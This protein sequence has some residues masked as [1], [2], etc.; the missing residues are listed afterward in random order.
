MAWWNRL[1]EPPEFTSDQLAEYL[2]RNPAANPN[3]VAKDGGQAPL[4]TDPDIYK[5]MYTAM[6]KVAAPLSMSPSG[7]DKPYNEAEALTPN[8]AGK[9]PSTQ[10]F[11]DTA[12]AP[13]T[14]AA[15]MFGGL[16]GKAALGAGKLAAGLGGK[17]AMF[18]AAGAADRAAIEAAQKMWARGAPD[19]DVLRAT[20]LSKG[21]EGVVQKEIPGNEARLHPDLIDK[22]MN[23]PTLSYRNRL[24][25][26]LEHPQLWKERPELAAI[27]TQLKLAPDIDAAYQGMRATDPVGATTWADRFKNWNVL[28]P[29]HIKA[30]GQ[31]DTW[32]A[33][34]L[35]E[36]QHPVQNMDR[37]A[38]GG[39][40][41]YNLQPGTNAWTLYQK[42]LQK[43]GVLEPFEQFL[44]TQPSIEQAIP[45]YNKRTAEM[46]KIFTNLNKRD[47]IAYDAYHQLGG[48]VQ[49]RNT[50][51]PRRLMSADETRNV[52]PRE[53]EDV[54]R[55]DQFVRISHPDYWR[56]LY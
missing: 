56:P 30:E 16:A 36:T 35:H 6:P 46:G 2:R 15:E 23:S 47:D 14:G 10:E 12:L 13:F 52:L 19:L 4:Q 49:A 29:G 50:E 32:L 5:Q 44:Q 3:V 21:V 40:V 55:E 24:D 31:P 1:N 48:E 38:S 27:P 33:T 8:A 22:V 43:I 28:P 53:T 9:V 42:H 11:R 26:M 39:G 54:A 45:A 20:G 41:N 18:L 7:D 25:Q 51:G 37:L 34:L 17:G